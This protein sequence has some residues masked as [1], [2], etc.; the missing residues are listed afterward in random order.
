MTSALAPM[1]TGIRANAR[2]GN[3]NQTMAVMRTATDG[4]RSGAVYTHAHV[5]A[6]SAHTAAI[7]LSWFAN[8]VLN[9][10]TMVKP[11]I[12]MA[13]ATTVRLVGASVGSGSCMRFPLFAHSASAASV[14]YQCSCVKHHNDAVLRCNKLAL[15]GDRLIAQVA[16]V[17][18]C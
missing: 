1:R 16:Q 17:A 14:A 6:S 11:T 7:W 9:G 10:A 8:V 13:K 5:A 12:P 18:R 3:T 2:S 4:Q 15:S